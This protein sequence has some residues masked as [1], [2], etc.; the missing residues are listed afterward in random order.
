MVWSQAGKS[1]LNEALNLYE[2]GYASVADLD[3]VLKDGLGLRWSFM[4][5]FETIDLNAPDGV[6]DYA[7]RYGHT[8]RDVAKTQLP[9]EWQAE[10]LQKIENERREVLSAAQLEARA[11]WRDNRLMA[12]VGH[13]RKQPV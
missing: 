6:L 10:T 8:Y 3:T 12:L 1:V 4:G 2:N 11:R 7:K 5:P 9:N 13:K